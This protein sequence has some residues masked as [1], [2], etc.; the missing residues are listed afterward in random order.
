[1]NNEFPINKYKFCDC[2][3]NAIVT[4]RAIVSQDQKKEKT[5]FSELALLSLLEDQLF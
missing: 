3:E 4:S 2:C 5:N 1:M